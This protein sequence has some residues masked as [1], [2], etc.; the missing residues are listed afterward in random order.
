MKIAVR[1]ENAA[2]I[3]AALKAVNGRAAAHTYATYAEIEERL[4]RA[5]ALCT[6][7]LPSK[8]IHK[9]A[10]YRAMSGGRVAK[11]YRGVRKVTIVTLTL[12]RRKWFL[13]GV[14]SNTLWPDQVGSEQLI[15]TPEQDRSAVDAFRKGYIVCPSM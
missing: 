7:L 13:T 2:K 9:G 12:G 3:E 4:R 8:G 6:K 5:D 15:L 10:R 1:P 11:C 14:S